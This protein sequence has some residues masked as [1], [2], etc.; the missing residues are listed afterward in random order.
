MR[1]FLRLCLTPL[2]LVILL[3]IVSFAAEPKWISIQNEHFN[4]YSTASERKTRE[5]LNQFERVRS[6]F[7][8]VARS[9]SIKP[10]PVTV[11]IFGSEKHYKPF[12]PNAIA[13]AYYSNRADRDFIV[14]G[15]L[16]DASS[17]FASHEYTHLILSQA[18][19]S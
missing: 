6:F 19:Y 9:E 17:R 18:G 14:L 13:A 16:D 7:N 3:P 15:E 1:K 10:N 12:R 11:V 4:V 2:L 8:Q 5:A